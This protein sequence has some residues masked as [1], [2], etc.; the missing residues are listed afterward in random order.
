MLHCLS[1]HASLFIDRVLQGPANE[2]DFLGGLLV[3][4]GE[5][6]VLTEFSGS[7]RVL[8][9]SLGD[10]DVILFV[11]DAVDLTTVSGRSSFSKQESN[12]S[13]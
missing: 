4:V 3:L 10:L 8:V 9:S 7:D 11:G 2:F 12:P 13:E 5:K 6:V 1:T